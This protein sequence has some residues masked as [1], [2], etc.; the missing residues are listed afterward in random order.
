MIDVSPP[1][2]DSGIASVTTSSFNGSLDTEAQPIRPNDSSRKS[3]S[4]FYTSDTLLPPTSEPNVGN[5]LSSVFGKV[6]YLTAV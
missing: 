4:S 6:R 1:G 5:R 3:R 2:S